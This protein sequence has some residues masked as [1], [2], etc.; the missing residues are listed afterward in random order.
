MDPEDY[1]TC[2]S[3]LGKQILPFEKFSKNYI[4]LVVVKNLKKDFV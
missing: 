4:F 3:L 2:Y 1:D